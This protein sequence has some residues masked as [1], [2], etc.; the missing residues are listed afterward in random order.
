MFR[1]YN[2][3]IANETEKASF[4]EFLEALV[5]HSPNSI[6]ENEHWATY[7]RACFPCD[8]QY[9]FILKLETIQEDL[10]W[11]FDK[12]NITK[13]SYPKGNKIP[14]NTNLLETKYL[15]E[16]SHPLQKA[17]HQYLKKDYDLFG[18]PI[19]DSIL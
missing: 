10:K 5:D 3:L 15:P 11:L 12:F 8:I 6:P 13:I 7:W 19:P 18:Y 4:Q 1:N 16:I 2:M 17:V 9:D 14:S